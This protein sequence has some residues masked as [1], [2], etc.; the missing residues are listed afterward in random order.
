[1]LSQ[2][3]GT[4]PRGALTWQQKISETGDRSVSSRGSCVGPLG[5]GGAMTDIR[6]SMDAR[7]ASDPPLPAVVGIWADR[8]ILGHGVAAVLARAPQPWLLRWLGESPA[9]MPAGT[10]GVGVIVAVWDM[11]LSWQHIR[12]RLA[13]WMAG[14]AAVVLIGEQLPNIAQARDDLATRIRWCPPDATATD[15]ITAVV[16]AVGQATRRSSVA[17]PPTLSD[18]ETRVVQ[19]V[20]AGWKVSA[21]ARRLE[22][23]P[24]TVHTYLRRIRRK[25]AD[26]GTPVASTLELYR[27]AMRWG[28]VQGGPA[29]GAQSRS[30]LFPAI[31]TSA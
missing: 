15:V 30:S 2:Q 31:E 3:E 8:T 28:L 6:D 26:A 17:L 14:G 27:E 22:V 16:A 11:P 12:K 4:Q 29:T 5:D 18:Q 13:S 9:S 1:M 19:M 20:A 10:V 24:H 25:F 7:T 21:V 23:S